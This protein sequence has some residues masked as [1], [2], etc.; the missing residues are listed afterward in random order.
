[1]HGPSAFYARETTDK[2]TALLVVYFIIDN[3]QES[4]FIN[5]DACTWFVFAI[6]FIYFTSSIC[7]KAIYLLVGRIIMIQFGFRFFAWLIDV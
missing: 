3:S 7:L 6:N 1:M 2:R 5:I 4:I